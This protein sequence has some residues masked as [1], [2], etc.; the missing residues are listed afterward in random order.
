MPD[1]YRGKYPNQLTLTSS[2]NSSL[3][4][5][6]KVPSSAY[7]DLCIRTAVPCRY[8]CQAR[9]LSRETSSRHIRRRCTVYGFKDA[10]ATSDTTYTEGLLPLLKIHKLNCTTIQ[11]DTT[12]RFFLCDFD[13]EHPFSVEQ[14]SSDDP[15]KGPLCDDGLLSSGPCV[16]GFEDDDSCWLDDGTTW[17]Q[18]S[19]SEWPSDGSHLHMNPNLLMS[20]S[21]DDDMDTGACSLA[22]RSSAPTARLSCPP[23]YPHD[24]DVSPVR[25]VRDPEFPGA[26][27]SSDSL[28]L[29]LD[30]SSS[31]PLCEHSSV[32]AF[33]DALDLMQ[34]TAPR[35]Q[36]DEDV[37]DFNFDTDP[38]GL[39]GDFGDD[40]RTTKLI[41][42]GAGLF[43]L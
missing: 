38:Y 16:S 5:C 26:S 23:P 21:S 18:D 8:R 31:S 20:L 30:D 36:A 6:W 13:E 10:F 19:E 27:H 7:C 40:C 17:S 25:H 2:R 11:F 39:E 37:L 35:V 32:L 33:D 9:R 4:P 3:D 28:D 22:A 24:G 42:R 29:I 34:E 14:F 12:Q 41:S 15:D 1:L 43:L